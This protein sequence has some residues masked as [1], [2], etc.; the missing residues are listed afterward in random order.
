MILGVGACS[1]WAFKALSGPTTFGNEFAEKLY[2][3]PAAAAGDLCPGAT[4]D[5]AGVQSAHDALVANG[6]TGDKR[7]LGTNVTT[8][9]G[10]STAVVGGTLGTSTV[11]IEMTKIGG[12][13]CVTNFLSST[14]LSTGFPDVSIPDVSV[15]DLSLPDLTVPEMEIT[16]AS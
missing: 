3:N 6:W 1:V 13:W 9:N 5:A 2:S 15:P 14:S 4:L 11:T 7:L 12:D 10:S 8:V 16:T